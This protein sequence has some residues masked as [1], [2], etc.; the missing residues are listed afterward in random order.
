LGIFPDAAE[1]ASP[2]HVGE[3]YGWNLSSRMALVNVCRVFQ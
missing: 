2:S 3:R 1:P